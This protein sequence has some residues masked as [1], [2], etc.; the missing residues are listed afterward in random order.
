MA[1]RDDVESLL[2]LTPPMF[3]VLVAL[4]GEEMHGW[5]I[6][7]EVS[8]RTDGR[9]VLSPGTLY[10]L[11]KRLLGEDLIV[12]SDRLPPARLDDE[13]RRYYRLTER[14]ERVV[15]AEM[16]R[17]QD[18]LALAAAKKLAPSPRKA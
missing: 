14:G 11:I 9:I 15:R 6:M 17:M 10:G 1:R 3:Q 5:A 12:E 13:R 18:A 2:P 7:K 16:R 4:A 8:G